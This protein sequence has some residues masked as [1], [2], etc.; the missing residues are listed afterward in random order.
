MLVR[1]PAE[2]S[3]FYLKL[4]ADGCDGDSEGDVKIN[5]ASDLGPC[6]V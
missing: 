1:H 3:C 5:A 6:G 2:W 4:R